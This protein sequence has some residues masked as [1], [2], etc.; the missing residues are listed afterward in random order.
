MPERVPNIS[1]GVVR[2]GQRKTVEPGKAFNFTQDEI[3]TIT[4]VAPG[5]LRK[6]VN[7]SK[8]DPD[9]APE[10]EATATDNPKTPAKKAAAKKDSTSKAATSEDDDI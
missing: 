2:E 6:A 5:A 7:E 3:D 8:S 10:P 4:K 9:P 1:V